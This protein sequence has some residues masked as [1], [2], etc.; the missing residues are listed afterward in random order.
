LKHLN[1]SFKRGRLEELAIFE[2]ILST[3]TDS[4]KIRNAFWAL[5]LPFLLCLAH[6]QIIGE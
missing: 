5:P 2:E 4:G 3:L 6:N 1:P